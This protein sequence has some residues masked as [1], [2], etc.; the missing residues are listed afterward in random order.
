M[1][2]ADDEPGPGRVDQSDREALVSARVLERVE[3][4]ESDALD[5]AP[6]GCLE[7]G[8][9]GRQVAELAGH[10]IDLVEMDVEHGPQIRPFGPAGQAVEPAPQPANPAGEEGNRDK[11]D[12]DREPKGDD[13]RADE[14]RDGGVEVDR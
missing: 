6:G 13:R 2:A 10:R 12:Q 3:P 7:D 9:S 8:R 1:E 14:G 4:D 5:R 11:E